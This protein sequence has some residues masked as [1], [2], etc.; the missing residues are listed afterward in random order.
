[1]GFAHHQSFSPVWSIVT[2]AIIAMGGIALFRTA[3]Q[4]AGYGGIL[5]ADS[6]DSSDSA[7]H[8]LTTR[9]IHSKKRKGRRSTLA[10][11]VREAAPID[12]SKVRK[13]KAGHDPAKPLYSWGDTIVVRVK[14]INRL[15]HLVSDWNTSSNPLAAGIVACSPASSDMM[16]DATEHWYHVRFPF[17]PKPTSTIQIQERD[18]MGKLNQASPAEAGAI[19]KL[20]QDISIYQRPSHT[21]QALLCAVFVSDSDAQRNAWL[22]NALHAKDQCHWALISYSNEIKTWEPVIALAKSKLRWKL[23]TAYTVDLGSGFGNGYHP[24]PLLYQKLANFTNLA[25]YSKVWIL[26]SDICF[27]RVNVQRMVHL[28]DTTFEKPLMIAQPVVSPRSQVSLDHSI[29]CLTLYTSSLVSWTK[30]SGREWE[31]L[32]LKPRT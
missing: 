7:S 18:I 30:S 15:Y 20:K 25:Y 8:R 31:W 26:D 27:T 5:V 14:K 17:L 13:P 4:S 24:K 16:T 6:L 21:Q 11:L 19:A 12:F 32:P 9:D 1:M 29:L 23:R 2:L 10:E 28:M 22:S 3:G